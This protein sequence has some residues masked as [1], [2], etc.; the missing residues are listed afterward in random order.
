M[1]TISL[2]VKLQKIYFENENSELGTHYTTSTERLTIKQ[3]EEILD[4]KEIEYKSVFQVRK[5][6]VDIELTETQLHQLIK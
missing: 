2:P 4:A 5:E 3:A 6:T 1:E